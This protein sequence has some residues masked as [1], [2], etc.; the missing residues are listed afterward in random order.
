MEANA[1]K[2]DGRVPHVQNIPI[3]KYF[4]VPLTIRSIPL[5]S[6]NWAP[7]HDDKENRDVAP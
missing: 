1:R 4:S 3:Y 5:G 2:K 7:R 6:I